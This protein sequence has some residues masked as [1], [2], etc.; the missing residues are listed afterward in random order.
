MQSNGYVH[1][2]VAVISAAIVCHAQA[3]SDDG[4][5]A[6]VDETGPYIAGQI[7]VKFA[8]Q[9]EAIA[10]G[11][12]ETVLGPNVQWQTP[13]HAPHAKGMPN[14]PH[15]LSYWRLAIVGPQADVVAL[16]AQVSALPGVVFAGPNGR[17]EPTHV[18]NDPLYPQQ[19]AHQKISSEGAWDVST[20]DSNIIIGIIDTGC[21]IAHEDLQ[22]LIWVNDDPPN[23]LDD[24]GNGFIDDTNGW[25]FVGN[26]NNIADV[27]G[28]GTQVSGISSA[29]IDNGLGI[30][31]IAN[32]TIMTSKWWHNSGSDFTVAQSVFYAVDNGAH[33]LNLSLGCQCLMPMTETAVNFAHDNGVV[34]V[35]SAG[36]SG[37]SQPGYPAA[38]PN[39][40]AVAAITSNDQLAGFS[41]WGPHL[42]VGAPSPGILTSSNQGVSLYTPNF[43]GTSAASPHVA[44]LAGLVL[45]VDPTLTPDEVRAF[46]NENADDLGAKGFD[47]FFGH[48]RINSSATIAAVNSSCPADLDGDGSVGASDLLALLA[49]WGT[50]PGGPPDFDGDG[51]VDASDLLVL[52]VNWGPCP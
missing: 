24:D 45:S 20:G 8:E 22:A 2:G 9:P 19:W 6:P 44:G 37:T 32:L 15:P 5:L 28:H 4:R 33:V 39:V 16:S 42:D 13:H 36:N 49:A 30:A 40:M 14:Q 17:P 41:N 46:I 25:N 50:D 1:L 34:V 18:P 21:L 11:N 52:L 10:L 12:V 3:F 29:V 35:A 27:F 23:G 38:Y 31:G 47:N 48:G 43:G 51:N 26:N 7:V